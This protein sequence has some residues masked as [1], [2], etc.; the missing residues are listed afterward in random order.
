MNRF[1]WLLLGC[2][3]GWAASAPAQLTPWARR[4]IFDRIQITGQRRLGYHAVTVSGDAEAYRS[5]TYYGLGGQRFTD[6]GH[7]NLS[8]HNVLGT[9]SFNVQLSDNRFSDPQ[10][11]KATLTYKNGPTTVDL[12]DIRG[13]LLGGN[14]FVLFSKSLRGVSALV[15]KGRFAAKGVYSESRGSAK[16]I[17]LNGNNSAGPY[18][19]GNSQIVADSE[20]VRIDGV[21]M[22]LG[23]DYVINYELGAITFI[24]RIVPPTSSIVV[25]FEALGFNANKGTVQGAAATYDFGRFGRAGITYLA[26]Q[27]R[28]SGGLS[29]RLEQFQGFGAA[30]TP[31]FLQFEPLLSRPITIRLDGV[32]QTEGIDYHFDTLN[33]SVFY[34]NRFVPATS[35]IDVVYTPK[36]TS[37]V[38]GDRRV[39]GLDYRIPLG[40]FG[41]SGSIG[42]SQAFGELINDVTP[43]SG[44]ARGIDG[45]Y[46]TGGL[47]LRGSIRDVPDG[48]VSV[49]SRGFN[50]NERAWDL[51]ADVLAGKWSY[52]ASNQNSSIAIRRTGTNGEFSF[53][54]T[55]ATRGQAYASFRE[56]D[57]AGWSLEHVRT[58][59]QFSGS[60]TR[61][62]TTT[63]STT[64]RIGKVNTVLGLER[65]DGYGPI[66]SS[67]P[68]PGHLSLETLRLEATYALGSAW[69]FRGRTSASRI[70]T[71]LGDGVGKDT[72]LS[73][74]YEPGDRLFV[75][76][77]Y[78]LS[79]SGQLAVLGAFQNGQGLGYG[80]NGFSGGVTGGGFAGA[81]DARLIQVTTGY[82]AS[83]RL[84]FDARYYETRSVG[85]VTSNSET[86][87]Y[88]LGAHW[89]LGRTHALDFSIDSSKTQFVGSALTSD[90]VT[91]YG[92]LSGAP[93]RWSY[94]LGLS[95]LVTGGNSQFGQDSA[96]FDGALSYRLDPRQRLTASY[97]SGRTQG[98]LP[99]SDSF[100]GLSHHYQLYSSAELVTSYRWR[101]VS[102]LDPMIT[103][104]AYR[105][106]GFD[107]ELAFN[108][109]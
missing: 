1:R 89:D 61:L 108:F 92:A 88:G 106:T 90:A 20:S 40:K 4:E 64:R 26:Q 100:F 63:L 81:T 35:I 2:C 105:S 12:G 7:V 22:R 76:A 65:Q 69:T 93:G 78:F 95:T 77:S 80:G 38:D 58:G 68:T 107:I 47:T 99:Q 54:R 31:Y 70:K 19:L 17:S 48:F 13:S 71:D 37:T 10:S 5:E 49:E 79:D 96:T 32:L 36:P 11:Q 87:A 39:V 86:T 43:L 72:S 29:T 101:N 21:A 33:T 53:D 109:R 27:A 3:V 55:R 94:R 16:T 41:Q 52:G 60:E 45:D 82:R 56:S 74:R 98:Y 6:V 84:A 103:S 73:V 44:T 9:I 34:F 24:N 30:S 18:Y 67:S 75:N 14:R 25:S 50:R 42:Y 85:S 23:Q 15:R 104:G 62:D 57:T 66:G 51:S 46:R 8:G 83:D 28:S 97:Q 59:S 102:N 91:F